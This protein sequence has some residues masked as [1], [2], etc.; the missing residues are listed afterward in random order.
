MRQF[1]KFALILLALLGFAS[2]SR[3]VAAPAEKRIALVI[4]NAN[5]QAGAL[6][7]AANDAGLIAQTL[8]AAGF[9]VTG[10]RDL[11]E[12]SLRHAFRDFVDKASAAGPGTVAFVYFGGYGLQLEGENYLL[13]VDANIGRDWDVPSRA[14][15]VADYV[16]PLAA[17]QLKVGIVVLDAARSLPFSISGQPLA[18]GLALVEPGP[19]M[20]M[21]FNAAP[22]TVAP[23]EQGPYGAYAQALAEMIREGG[24]SLG[25]LFERVRLRVNEVTKGAQVPWNSSGGDTSFVF[26][27]RTPDAPPVQ[28]SAIRSRPIR[29]LGGRDG[30]L[31]ALQ[32]DSL[33]GYEEFLAAYPDDAMTTRVR[34]LVAARREAITWRRTYA[35]DTPNAY[36]SYLR[37]YPYGPHAADARRRLAELAAALEPP[38]AFAMLDYDVPPP[39][40]EEV[41][42][43]DRPV[44]V[45]D[46]F[47]FPPPPPAP[48]Y[49]LPPPPPEF[50]ILAPPVVVV[51]T[52]VL[53]IPVF[54][55]IPDWCHPPAYVVPP[56]SNVIFANIHNTV[57]V[58]ST[59]NVVT[60][61]NRSG[62]VVS[63][64]PRLAPGAGAAAIGASLPP[65]VAKK[66]A[67]I[68][69]APAAGPPK[70]RSKLPVGQPL[71][72]TAGQPLPPVPGKPLGERKGAA[73]AP[74]LNAPPP[75]A[76]RAPSGRK[77]G[78]TTV[79]TP[80]SSPTIGKPPTAGHPLPPVSGKPLGERKGAATAPSL[81]AP[82]PSTPPAPRGRK[83][84]ST[85]VQ[86]P[87]SSPTVGGPQTP[88]TTPRTP[89]GR[90]PARPSTAVQTPASSPPATSRKPPP[91]PSTT[92]H[93]H[94]TGRNPP[95]ATSH[96][97][98]PPATVR[99]PAPLTTM[100]PPRAAPAHKPPP[101]SPTIHSPPPPGVR[102]P[103][104][105]VH[106]PPP[107]S[108]AAVHSAPPPAMVRRPTPPP[109]VHNPPAPP[110]P[111]YHPP[112]PA[113]AYHPAPP[114]VR[115]PPPPPVVNR[116][117]APRAAARSCQIVNGRQV[118][119]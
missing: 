68:Q 67:L 10:A 94:G 1:L 30:Y 97:P 105:M 36:W 81:N 103:T 88:A 33:Q 45:F 102:S 99:K 28:T 70:P 54:V 47:D 92:M 43:V 50:V 86:T 116:A 48:V 12:D 95:S 27:E 76:P 31:A 14:V 82:P 64:G 8:Q 79:Q 23:A 13:P 63:S 61:Q 26:F 56:P 20:L 84:G 115:A 118:C 22:G 37:R 108:P 16:K 40:P 75:P 66:A 119:R 106:R 34:A 80:P 38:P 62:Q 5:Y 60:V 32:R 42:Y 17:L 117:P 3:M 96:V 52:F 39:L 7:T 100:Q 107:P 21:A 51:E 9:D 74:M 109:V 57:I 4:G 69:P 18:G 65:S 19:G 46:D 71:P 25:E 55:P 41:A 78:S 6:G 72:G 110:Q 53:P 59:T 73:T 112:S 101:L 44:L 24:L 83:L 15:R 2:S 29:D 58:N 114:A 49:F 91:L 85:T 35:A 77:L 113:A 104:T 89:G 11:D 93:T 87:P 98:P 111:T 90:K